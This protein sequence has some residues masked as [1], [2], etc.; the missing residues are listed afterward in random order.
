[1][2]RKGVG[3]A[4]EQVGEGCDVLEAAVKKNEQGGMVPIITT[5]LKIAGALGRPVS[6]FVEDEVGQDEFAVLTPPD[7]DRQGYTSHEGISLSS[8][9]GPYGRFM[10]AG[11]RATGDAGA[12][13][14]RKPMQHPGQELVHVTSGVVEVTVT[15]QSY[16]LRAGSSPP[17]SPHHPPPLPN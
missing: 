7:E 13:S 15:G 9:S 8:I 17:L 11:A 16:Q 10:L 4:L 2:R 6:Y 14:G 12:T 1:M 3:G 5:L